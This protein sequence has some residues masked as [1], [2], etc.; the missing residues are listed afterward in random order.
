[1]TRLPDA[2]GHF[3]RYGGRFVPETLMS[4]LIELERAYAAAKRDPRFHARLAT[5]LRDYAGRP[6][7]V[8]FA[9]RLS[10]PHSCPRPTSHFRL[11]PRHNPGHTPP[12]P[13]F[14]RDRLSRRPAD[15]LKIPY[16]CGELRPTSVQQS[17]RVGERR[18]N[19]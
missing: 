17:F 16:P 19:S 7:P 6:T 2:G 14:P 13:S 12:S 3:G 18:E 10:A 5:L 15:H 11:V 4:P 1:M 9:R 8:Y